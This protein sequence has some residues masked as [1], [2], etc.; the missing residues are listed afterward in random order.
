MIVFCQLLLL[1]HLVMKMVEL[2]NGL[3]NCVTH[4][5]SGNRKPCYTTAGKIN[6][7]KTCEA[8]TTSP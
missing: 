2:L 5:Q 3:C 1:I 6:G 7:N 8:S 4:L